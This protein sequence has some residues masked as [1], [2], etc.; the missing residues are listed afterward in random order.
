LLFFFKQP[1]SEYIPSDLKYDELRKFIQLLIRINRKEGT[2]LGIKI[3]GGKGSPT[4]YKDDDD[5]IFI[6]K[7]LPNS[8]A[9]KTGLKV[10]DKLLKVNQVDLNDLSHQQAV[11]T[12]KQAVV[13]VVN[14]L[15]LS[16]FQELDMNKLFFLQIPNSDD[17]PNNSN[18]DIN[19]GISASSSSSFDPT[20]GTTISGFRINYN[21]NTHQQQ[22]VEIIF[23]GDHRRFGQLKKG[24]ILLQINGRNVDAMSEKDLNKYVLNSSLPYSPPSTKTT[25]STADNFRIFSLTIYRPFCEDQ[26][27][28]SNY[29]VEDDDGPSH[30]D[31]EN[32]NTDRDNTDNTDNTNNRTNDNTSNNKQQD[33]NNT[34]PGSYTN[35]NTHCNSPVNQNDN[36]N[37]NTPLPVDIK[38]E[39][40]T[41]TPTATTTTQKSEYPIE[42][43]VILKE[44]GAMGLSIVGGGNVPCHPFG[45]DKPGI[46][47]SK[48]VPDGPAAVT[49]SLRV[50]DRLIKVNNIDIT[51]KSHD[52]TV[53]E[54]KSRNDQ[55]T[56]L[57]S[58]DPQPNGMQEI[59]LHRS[60]PEET[61][62]IR[63]N[64]GIENKSAN[65]NDSTDEGIFV[66]NLIPGTIAHQNGHLK[67]GTRIMEVS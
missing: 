63:I 3:A 27:Q 51:E 15:T 36:S 65:P 47:I 44:N 55:V 62:G 6:T 64:G 12:L 34:S 9:L 32:S 5:G 7:I 61:L 33:P 35:T 50:G 54:L 16:I 42:E 40:T 38:V 30:Q 8:P 23:I 25:T 24:D 26:A 18:N 21:F 29:I 45:I 66:V 28:K 17:H 59:M 14:Q 22:E 1:A 53:D 46:F 43:V 19:G 20:N 60:F 58:H 57:V 49:G 52:E 2:G 31:N 4:P 41:A 48:I 13:S 67:C 39:M 37:T 56:L 11:D 10:G